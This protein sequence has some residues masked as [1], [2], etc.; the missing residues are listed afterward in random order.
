MSPPCSLTYID[1]HIITL[2]LYV[3]DIILT[4]S[5]FALVHKF[6]LCFV[7]SFCHKGFGGDLHYFLGVQVVRSP[8]LC[9]SENMYVSNFTL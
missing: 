6:Y 9:L 5:R 3:D 1:G 7:L 4:S 2:V 8:S